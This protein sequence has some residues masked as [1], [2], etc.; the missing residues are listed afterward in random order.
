MKKVVKI[1]IVFFLLFASLGK[2]WCQK[3]Y[4]KVLEASF[5][6]G[7][8]ISNGQPWAD[9][10][11]DL[12]S[13]HA[14]DIRL[15]WRKNTNSF[16]GQLYRYP[17]FGVGL[18][19]TL[20]YQSEIGRPQG[21]Y[22]FFD[23]PFK[24]FSTSRKLNLSYFGHLGLGF[25]LNPYDSLDNP[26]NR[27]IGSELNS[28]IHLGLKLNYAITEQTQL[29]S[30]IGL[31]HFSNGSTKKPNA[32]INLIPVSIGVRYNFDKREEPIPEL[33]ERPELLRSGYWSTAFYFG[34][35]NY[36]VGE[37]S[38]F[39]GGVNLTYLWEKSYKYRYGVGLDVF[40]APGLKDRSGQDEV[41]FWDQTSI[42]A[43]GSWEWKLTEKLYI[44]VGFGVYL[45]RNEENQEFTW[46]YERVGLRYSL[47]D[48]LFTGIQIKAHKLKADFFEFTVGYSFK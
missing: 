16:Y 23:I 3:Q 11:K 12:V 6:S 37:P 4:K 24:E 30:M 39:R 32:G 45:H 19:T 31:K 44:P 46:F 48:Q 36:E 13:Y 20:P 35:K 47:T 38:Y 1:Y 18:S 15:G 9:A 21:V 29:F 22:W 8:L 27:Y 2:A 26:L 41:T 28:Y 42:A 43:V 25:N 17:V 40:F 33:W 7:P 5:E 10:I 14:I 34:S